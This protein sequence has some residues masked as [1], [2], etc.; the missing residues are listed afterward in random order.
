MANLAACRISCENWVRTNVRRYHLQYH[1]GSP[2]A[3]VYSPIYPKRE[4]LH[5]N[6]SWNQWRTTARQTWEQVEGDQARW[7][8]TMTRM[9]WIYNHF[10]EMWVE[11][12]ASSRARRNPRCKARAIFL[13][14]PPEN[15]DSMRRKRKRRQPDMGHRRQPDTIYQRSIRY[16]RRQPDTKH[17]PHIQRQLEQREAKSEGMVQYERILLRHFGGAWRHWTWEQSE[18]HAG[19]WVAS[20]KPGTRPLRYLWRNLSAIQRFKI[21][22]WPPKE[23][24]NI[25][26]YIYL[27]FRDEA[28]KEEWNKLLRNSA[29]KVHRGSGQ[30]VEEGSFTSKPENPTLPSLKNQ[31]EMWVVY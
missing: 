3:R 16:K 22:S 20:M 11:T 17:H 27:Y 24:K 25:Y 26:I 23:R 6:N 29:I 5:Q 15:T 21:M 9:T 8:L 12:W 28:N 30:E 7:T 1:T 18:H 19:L 10:Q 13:R 4:V 14:N 2:I 31:V